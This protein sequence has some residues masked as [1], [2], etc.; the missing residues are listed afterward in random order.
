[1]E[2]STKRTDGQVPGLFPHA[3]GTGAQVRMDHAVYLSMCP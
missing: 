1:M 3:T 2:E